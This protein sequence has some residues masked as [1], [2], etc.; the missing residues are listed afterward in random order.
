M[1]PQIILVS[2]TFGGFVFS[3]VN[4][5]ERA[6]NHNAGVSAIVIAIELGL[7]Y[8]GGFFS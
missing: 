1:A 3:C 8:W 2:L 6:P 5:G 7:L 4:H